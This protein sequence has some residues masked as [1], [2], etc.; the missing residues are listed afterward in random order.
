MY[1][2]TKSQRFVELVELLRKRMQM[3]EPQFAKAIEMKYGTYRDRMRD[4]ETFRIV[5]LLKIESVG[6]L[7]DVSPSSVWFNKLA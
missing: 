6:K 4:P 1:K 5:E 7:Y 3:T 2:V